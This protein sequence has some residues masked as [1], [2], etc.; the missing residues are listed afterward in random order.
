LIALERR[1]ISVNSKKRKRKRRLKLFL[2][3]ESLLRLRALAK[4][5]LEEKKSPALNPH[6]TRRG[7]TRHCNAKSAYSFNGETTTFASKNGSPSMPRGGR[8]KAF[9]RGGKETRRAFSFS[10]AKKGEKKEGRS[11]TD[12]IVVH[13]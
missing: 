10:A 13:A 6:S 2:R 5:L 12:R 11:A 7:D 4:E 3:R 1:N 9:T 8:R